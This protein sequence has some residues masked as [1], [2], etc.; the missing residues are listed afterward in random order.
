MP[1]VAQ[2]NPRYFWRTGIAFSPVISIN[3]II[4]DR[5]I[6]SP[7]PTQEKIGQHHG[8]NS[9]QNCEDDSILLAPLKVRE[10]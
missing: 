5:S 7:Q 8:K 2:I 1:K 10:Q 3:K 6:L 4:I 9:K